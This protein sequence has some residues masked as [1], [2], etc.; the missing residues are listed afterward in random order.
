MRVMLAQ[1]KQ[2]FNNT[3]YRYITAYI[4]FVVTLIFVAIVIGW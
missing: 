3:Y 4:A 2:S 1:L